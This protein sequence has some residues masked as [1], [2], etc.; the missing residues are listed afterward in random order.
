[1]ATIRNPFPCITA[2]T[3]R[4]GGTS[5][6]NMLTKLRRNVQLGLGGGGAADLRHAFR[7]LTRNRS[8]GIVVVLVLA[9]SVAINTVIFFMLEGVVLRPLPYGSP[10]RLVRIYDASEGQPKFPM[11]IGHYLDYR[12]NARSLDGIALYTGQDMELSA[13][14]S[15]SEQLTGVA[16]TSDY[17]SV[18]GKFPLLGR[19]FTDEDLRS[20][21]RHVILSH[22]LWR[23]RFQSDPAIIGKSIRLDRGPWTIVGVAPEG[24][25]HVGGD[26]RSPLQG[27]SVDIWIPLAVDRPERAIRGFHY[28]NAIARVSA[29][30][31]ESQA[32]GELERLAITY[33]QGYPQ[34]GAYRARMEPLL[35]EVTGRSRQIVWLLATAGGLV[36]LVAC[37]NIAGLSIARALSRRHELSLRRALGANGWQL[38]RVGLAE[39]LLI[40]VVGA[41]VGLV[42][43]AAGLPLVRQLLPVDF[44]RAHEIAVTGMGALF[45]VSVAIAT[46]VVA[47]VVPSIGGD[48][49]PSS[50]QRVTSGYEPRRRRAFLVVGEV[51]LAG[52][53]CAGALFLLRSYQEIGARD[54]GFNPEGALTFRLT[55][56]SGDRVDPGYVARVQED[57]RTRIGE[58]PGVVAVGASTNLPWSGYDEN[59]GFGIVGRVAEDNDGPSARFQA[60]SPG[61]FEA[62]GMRLIGGRLFDRTRDATGAALTVIA[63]DALADRYFPS[64]NAVGSLV[65]LWGAE[66][67]IIGVVQGIKDYPADLDIKPAFW[68]PLGQVEF[69]S[70]FYAVRSSGIDPAA[71]TPAVTAAVHGVD[72]ELP[73][74]DIRTLERRAAGALAARR[75]ALWLFQV[76]TVLALVL[77]AAGIYGLLAYVVRQ[78]RKELGIR[79]ALGAR[80]ADLWSMILSDGLKMAVAGAMCSLLLIPV[81]GRLLQAFL[82]NVKAF[83][84]FTMVGA[85]AVLLTVSFL[86]SLGPAF[87]AA[88]SDP[89]LALREE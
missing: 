41:L 33:S 86:A 25:Q 17:F 55:I 32:R 87:S 48:A 44:P 88:R 35:N 56:R 52:V 71:L 51:A 2:P 83:D 9:A 79:V 36:L 75:F 68:F 61:Y 1:M 63:N 23:E 6:Q 20:G 29:E 19:S 34:Y 24:F 37:G 78:R 74:A 49:L 84:F 40:G 67:Q 50:L 77:A 16:I 10:E 21:V 27:E 3:L 57:I 28:C 58:I 47:G 69:A 72:P 5:K 11:S 12:A 45:A 60:A 64:G 80:R 46:V 73:L 81:G 82:Y 66:R 59:T 8:F 26:Y 4:Q 14:D 15:R 43:A 22:R 54:H 65:N 18:L 70:V 62:A 39:N 85:P 89:A 30:F 38:L 7:A 76:F 13:A 42:L 31:T 53:L